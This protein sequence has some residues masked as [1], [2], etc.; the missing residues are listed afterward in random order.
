METNANNPTP[1]GPATTPLPEPRKINWVVFLI[2]LL[3]PVIASCVAGAL[4]SRNGDF[5][6]V[7]ALFGG[8]IAGIICGVM[9]GR[10]IGKNAGTRIMLGILF[11]IL[12]TVV[13][14]GMSC[15]GCMAGGYQM[16]FG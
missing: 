8:G 12:L 16:R 5:A 9:L 10:R 4:D 1:L 13:C 2:V 11:A 15:F 6:P 3:A 7:I 14:I